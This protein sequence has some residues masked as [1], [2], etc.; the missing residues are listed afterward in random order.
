MHLTS[1]SL[2]ELTGSSQF[3]AALEALK[4]RGPSHFQIMPLHGVRLYF[5]VYSKAESSYALKQFLHLTGMQIT[6]VCFSV[7]N[8]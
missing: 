7:S 6:D 8:R 3:T 1:D 5:K 2:L 4:L